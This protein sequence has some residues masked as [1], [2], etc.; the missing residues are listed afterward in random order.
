MSGLKDFLKSVAKQGGAGSGTGLS[1]EQV[2][3]LGLGEMLEGLKLSRAG[4][5][6]DVK[7]EHGTKLIIPSGLSYKDAIEVLQRQHKIS[8]TE[9]SVVEEIDAF[10]FD[11]AFALREAMDEVVGCSFQ[12][13]IRS[14]FGD[15]KPQVRRIEVAPGEFVE[16]PWGRMSVPTI[17]G[18]VDIGPG[19]RKDGTPILQVNFETKK[20]FE[21]KCRELVDKAR[22]IVRTRSIYRGRAIKIDFS[23]RFPLPHFMSKDLLE[24]GSDL[25]L[26]EET[27]NAFQD[28]VLTLIQ[29]PE[30]CRKHGVPLKRGILF[31]GPFG[32]GKTLSAYVV[33]QE[34]IKKGWT[35]IYVEDA[36]QLAE[37]RTIAERYAPAVVFVEDLDTITRV[38][39]EIQER[40]R[41][42]IDGIDTKS[43]EVMVIG[44][45]N[46]LSELK[47]KMPGILRPGRL[48]ALIEVG[49][50]E[51]AAVE[52][53]MR[54]YAGP[55]LA[56][57]ADI[58]EAAGVLQGQSAAMVRE[59]VERSKAA[60][61]T[62]DGE[63]I[64]GEALHR[65]SQAL[66]THIEAVGPDKVMWK[67]KEEKLGIAVR[68]LLQDA[69]G[70]KISEEEFLEEWGP[71]L[72]ASM[73][74]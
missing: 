25:V 60:M 27:Q 70:K 17:D 63:S 34:A 16:I 5:I 24:T 53:L 12:E 19:K 71:K 68:N 1:A 49:F 20:K 48:D 21:P 23:E 28:S 52:R 6:K 15:E 7:V 31:Y 2:E 46:Y 32:T 18:H 57:A 40:I 9:V 44:T 4:R 42:V 64:D 72:R 33:A 58:S 22:E 45:T 69:T 50:P 37:A 29:K 65:A 43:H 8:E 14:F 3:E 59:C 39:D 13:T 67:S 10:P 26:N 41:N 47:D 30:Q 38:D 61:I 11:A 56:E 55:L 74:I 73:G 62:I 35:F 66:K 54:Q 51:S 36:V